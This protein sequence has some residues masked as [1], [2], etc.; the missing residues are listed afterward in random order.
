M[1]VN[2]GA[3][4]LELRKVLDHLQMEL[5]H[6]QTMCIVAGCDYLKNVHGI[7]IK[8]AKEIVSQDG[9]EDKL[10]SNPNAPPG[11][12]SHL[13]RAQYI[14]RHQT[15]FNVNLNCFTPLHPWT[16]N[17]ASNEELD[18]CGQYPFFTLLT[19]KMIRNVD[20]K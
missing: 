3:D 8:R 19:S 16:P 12:I 10:S 14:F 5:A 4:T 17:T 2:G 7:G 9:Y 13:H 6:F 15:V 1:D 18:A 11:Y 20:L